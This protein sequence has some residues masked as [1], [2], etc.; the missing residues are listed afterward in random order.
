MSDARLIVVNTLGKLRPHGHGLSGYCRRR[1]SHFVVPLPALIAARGADSPVVGM[2]PVTCQVWWPGDGDPHC[3][4]A[5]LA[6]IAK[7]DVAFGLR[8][9]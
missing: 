1:Q 3:G 4:A 7:S 2:R 9:G 6:E 5:E 8:H